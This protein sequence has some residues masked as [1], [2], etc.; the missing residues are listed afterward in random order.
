MIS[1]PQSGS[2]YPMS[3]E[4][5]ALEL[6]QDE[7]RFQRALAVIEHQVTHGSSTRK[8]CEACNVPVSTFY[9]WLQDGVLTEYLT[10]ARRGRAELT[11][12]VA[13]EAAPDVLR[14]MIA[15]ATGK[16]QVRGANPVAAAKL[17]LEIAAGKGTT[18]AAEGGR[19][20]TNWSTLRR[21][22]LVGTTKRWPSSTP[23]RVCRSRIGTKS[24]R[25]CR[26][27]LTSFGSADK[28]TPRASSAAPRSPI[29]TSATSPNT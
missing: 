12:A 23:S 8:A 7:V 29:G 9:K 14:Y 18:S 25:G 4:T 27:R 21:I 22:R 2:M 3:N 24:S 17:V 16:T 11:S 19:P 13:N 1:Y 6:Y 26:S 10:D 15:L 28:F 20:T 5:T